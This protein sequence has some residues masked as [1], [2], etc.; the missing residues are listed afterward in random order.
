MV[1]LLSEKQAEDIILLDIGRVAT[2]AD[3]FIIASAP[4]TR[5]IQA[6]LDSIDKELGKKSVAVRREGNADSGWVLLD[7][8]DVIVHLFDPEMRAYYKI[9]ELWSRGAA[10]VRF[11]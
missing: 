2:F 1:E 7:L 11:Q 4:T 10:V 3:Y 8:G 6:L 5:Q 9:E